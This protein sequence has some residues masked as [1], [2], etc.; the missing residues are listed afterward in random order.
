VVWEVLLHAEAVAELSKL[1]AREKAAVHTA[2][3]KLRKIGPGLGY[4]HTSHVRSPIGLGSFARDKAVARGGR[5]TG[6]LMV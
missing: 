3:E 1:P 5:S 6:T 2:L 4:P